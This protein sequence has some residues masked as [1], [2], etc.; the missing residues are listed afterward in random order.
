MANTINNDVPIDIRKIRILGILQRLSIA[1][2]IIGWVHV[3]SLQLKYNNNEK[4]LSSSSLS[5]S[6]L[7]LDIL[8]YWPD[9]TLA[10]IMSVIYF[11]VTFVWNYDSSGICPRGYL[12]P[13]GLSENASYINCVGGAAGKL[14]KLILGED[15][16]SKEFF[17]S[18]LYDP[19]I[20]T[21]KI[22]M[23]NSI[24]NCNIINRQNIRLFNIQQESE[25][26]LGFTTSIVLTLI[27]LQVGKI[28]TTYRQTGQRLFRWIMWIIILGNKS[29]K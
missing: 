25:G 2:W 27:G 15:H 26:I 17:G 16:I 12:G 24:N 22:M 10:I 29:V 8:P 19:I 4:S 13:G 20:T 3:L 11:L 1:N 18:S 21:T 14:D 6:Y 5:I 23:N 7:L 28:I 9:W